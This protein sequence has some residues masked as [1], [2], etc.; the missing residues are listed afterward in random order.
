MANNINAEQIKLVFFDIDETLYV[1]DK[2]Y[3]PPSVYTAIRK[4]KENGIVPGIATGRARGVFPRVIN[5]LIEQEN[6][7]MMVTI[8]GQHNSYQGK[9]IERHPIAIAKIER[10]IEFFEQHRIIYAFIS[11]DRIAVSGITPEMQAALNPI[12]TDYVVDKQHYRQHE[13]YQM[14]AFYD[15]SQ[16][17]QIQA[18]GVLGEDLKVLRWHEYSVDVL[19]DAGSK[20]RGIDTIARHLGYTAANV[21]AFGDGINDREMIA[22][23]GLG[24]AMGNA[25]PELKRVAQY[26]TSDIEDDGILTA[27][28]ALGMI[29]GFER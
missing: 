2:A 4:L 18:S 1:K 5:E 17:A 23:V 19:E 25:I 21:M 8:N 20:A 29:D 14:L 10:L 16:D 13:V 11:N 24:V 9:V 27:L 22:H 6:I 3:V 26:V 28:V 12:T 7:D 15:A